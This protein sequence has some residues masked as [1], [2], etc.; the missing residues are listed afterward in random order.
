MSNC[1]WATTRPKSGT[2]RPNTP[3]SFIHRSTSSGELTQ[4]RTS[5]NSRFARGSLRTFSSISLASRAAARIAVGWI[6]SPSLRGEREQL[7]QPDRF[8][9][10]K[11]VVRD[12][13]AAAVEDEA[14]QALG[15][16][17]DSRKGESKALLGKLLIKLRQEDSGEVADRLRVDEVELHEPFDRGF[18]GPVGVAHDLGDMLLMVEPEALL[19]AAGGQVKM[20]AHRPEEALGALELL[21]LGGGEQADSDEVGGLLDAVDV[22]ADPVERVEIA[23]AALAVLDVGLDDVAACRPSAGGARR[24]RRAWRRRIRPRC[25]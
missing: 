20:A 12:R 19:G 2:K 14:R 11:F 4:V 23:Q 10:E 16:A 7:D 3:A 15:P 1:I 22:F 24:A 6:S 5:R 21:E 8:L 13:Q 25:R 9:C 17:S 18:P